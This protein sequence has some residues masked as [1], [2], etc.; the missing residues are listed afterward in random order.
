MALLTTAVGSGHRD[1]D[2]FRIETAL[3]SLRN[4]PD[5]RLMMM[6]L[7]FPAQACAQ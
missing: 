2:W 5:F 3:D 1:A 4:R 6:D 7:A